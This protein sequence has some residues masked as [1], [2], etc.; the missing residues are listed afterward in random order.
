MTPNLTRDIG[1]AERALRALLD[2]HL[3]PVD[4]AFPEWVVLTFLAAETGGLAADALAG[5]LVAGRVCG[6]DEGRRAVAGLAGRG[7]VAAGTDRRVALTPEGRSLQAKIAA[8]VGTVVGHLV[9]GLP[10][11]DLAATRRTL[12]AIT[13]RAGVLLSAA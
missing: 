10:E 12:A 13:G 2:R 8:A 9:E 3:A 5:R 4:L 11:A 7:L 6:A 1:Q